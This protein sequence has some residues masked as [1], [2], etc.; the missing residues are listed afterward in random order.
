M[1]TP[2]SPAAVNKLLKAEE[3]EAA[4]EINPQV[5]MAKPGSFKPKGQFG[6]PPSAKSGKGMK[7]VKM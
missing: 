7:P 1:K 4:G 5:K 2:M 6:L 3:A